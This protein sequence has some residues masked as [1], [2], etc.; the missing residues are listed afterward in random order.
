MK[1]QIT[2]KKPDGTMPTEVFSIN[3]DDPHKDD[4]ELQIAK[5]KAAASVLFNQKHH[6]YPPTE[7]LSAQVLE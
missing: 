2:W 5:A 7:L 3:P 1:V 4:Q 6:Q